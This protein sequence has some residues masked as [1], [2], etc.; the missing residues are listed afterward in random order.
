[1]SARRSATPPEPADEGLSIGR[2]PRRR[3]FL[4]ATI[5][6]VAVLGAF[7]LLRPES[8]AVHVNTVE[9]SLGRAFGAAAG[10]ATPGVRC[11]TWGYFG[12]KGWRCT[13]RGRR[14]DGGP[15]H[16]RVRRREAS[17]WEAVLLED[18]GAPGRLRGCG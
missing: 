14:G 17:C 18:E 16:Y 10:G 12:S 2:R 1:V 7:L 4:G 6:V 13:V 11:R 9:S 8:D 3:P 5:A 15:I